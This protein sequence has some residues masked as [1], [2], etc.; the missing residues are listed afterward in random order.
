MDADL[1]ELLGW[2]DFTTKESYL[3]ETEGFTDCED[4]VSMFLF[5]RGIVFIVID[6]E[7]NGK[8]STAGETMI[9]SYRLRRH[10]Q[11]SER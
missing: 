3:L 7:A 8:D 10:R 4:S 9:K 6:D 2:I 5:H 11:R 1:K